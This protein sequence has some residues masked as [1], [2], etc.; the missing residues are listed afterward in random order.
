MHCK[1]GQV[2]TPIAERQRVNVDTMGTVD[3]PYRVAL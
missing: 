1:W 3:P 2:T